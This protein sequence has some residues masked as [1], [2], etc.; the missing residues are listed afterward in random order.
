MSESIHIHC[1]EVEEHA[2]EIATASAYFEEVLLIPSD[3]K[4]TISA[5]ENVQEGFAETQN[6]LA[7]FGQCLD[8]EAKNIRSLGLVFQEHD[9]MMK[10][11]LEECTR[12]TATESIGE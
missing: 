12:D 1:A 9:E 2:G 10:A 4:S 5:N 7:L 3:N 6:A 11:L 8:Q